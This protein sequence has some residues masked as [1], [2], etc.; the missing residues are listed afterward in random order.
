MPPIGSL[1]RLVA[2]ALLERRFAGDDRA[3]VVI[4]GL[5]NQRTVGH[6][7]RIR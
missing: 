4:D 2:Q 3:Q 5:G 1:R 6:G 7:R